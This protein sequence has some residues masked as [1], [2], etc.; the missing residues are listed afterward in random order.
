MSDFVTKGA[1]VVASP[2]TNPDIFAEAVNTSYTLKNGYIR[3]IPAVGAG[4][5]KIK[6]LFAGAGDLIQADGRNC[7]WDPTSPEELALKTITPAFYKVNGEECGESW[8]AVRAEEDFY[9]ANQGKVPATDEEAVLRYAAKRIG[10]GVEAQVWSDIVTEAT[11][12]TDVIDVTAVAGGFTIN[13]ILD[14]VA[15]VYQNIPTGVLAEAALDPIRGQ[16]YCFMNAGD[17]RLVRMALNMAATKTNVVLP[18]WSIENGVVRFL[19]MIIV[20]VNGIAANKMVAGAYQNF[21][22][23]SNLV[24]GDAQ[25]KARYGSDLDNENILFVKS[26][27]TLKG[28][29]AFGAE[30]ILY[31]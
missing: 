16:I 28:S 2:S 7:A 5:V 6:K 21:A 30:V 1:S 15:K 13:N 24:S 17:Y 4:G 29:Y 22:C 19:D 23:V 31:A 27:F 11:S 12:D 10:V 20:P 26:Q 3:F 18:S 9:N 8:D 14:E 25:I